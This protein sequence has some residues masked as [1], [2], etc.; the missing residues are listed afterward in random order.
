VAGYGANGFQVFDREVTDRACQY[1]L[2]RRAEDR[3]SC[4][5]VGLMLPHNPLIARKDLFD[6]YLAR[7]PVPPEAPQ[8][9]MERL[10]PAM[11]AWR[12]RR[13]VPGLTPGQNHRAM[14][15]YYALVTEMDANVGRIVQAVR[16]SP[17]AD[18]TAVIYCSDH[19]DMA[20]AQHGMWW[21]SSH[22]EGS[23]RVPLIASWPGRFGGGRRIGANVSL[24]D[25]GPTV[26]DLAGCAPLEGIDGRSLARFMR[27]SDVPG[28][29]DEI[30]CEYLGDHGDQPSCMI[31]RGS[32]KLI[33]YSEFDSCQVF[34]LADDPGEMNDLAGAAEHLAL[35]RELLA[36]IHKQ[37]SA[38]EMLEYGNRQRH[39]WRLIHT[40]GHDFLPH[41][42]KH[43]CA[44][45]EANQFDFAQLPSGDAVAR[46]IAPPP[47]G[48]R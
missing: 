9:Y 34:N 38:K 39:S 26:L 33:Y 45:A 25:L 13:G 15:A 19:G 6:Y 20:G 4:M 27:G 37:W 46:R 42:V 40:C 2:S 41:A 14:A 7:L 47:A 18:N 36:R 16:T 24:I 10:H 12:Q 17:T 43:H 8:D 22:Y 28:W 29:P 21:K 11:L 3:P 48:P 35:A 32:W 5:V 30:F 31:R 44:G 23:A 1:I